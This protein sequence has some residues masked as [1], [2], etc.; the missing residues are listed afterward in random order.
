MLGFEGLYG[1]GVRAFAR[2]ESGCCLKSAWSSG[3]IR[4][5]QRA[6]RRDPNNQ[7]IRKCLGKSYLITVWAD[8]SGWRRRRRRSCTTSQHIWGLPKRRANFWDSHDKDCSTGVPLFWE[9]TISYAL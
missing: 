4:V 5:N 6:G 8:C 3:V 2:P 1:Y 9:T 7:L